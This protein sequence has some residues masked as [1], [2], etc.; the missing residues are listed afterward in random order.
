MKKTVNRKKL[1]LDIH[2]V[3]IVS[4]TRPGQLLPSSQ[5]CHPFTTWMTCPN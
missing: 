2:T 1:A 5:A 4:I 3:R